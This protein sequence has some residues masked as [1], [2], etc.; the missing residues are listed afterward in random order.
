MIEGANHMN[1]SFSEHRSGVSETKQNFSKLV[2]EVAGGEVR[3][4]VEKN[5]LPVAAI[6]STNDYERFKMMEADRARRIEAIK[7]MSDSL[8][9]IPLETLE[10]EVEKAIAESR[11]KYIVSGAERE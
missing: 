2:N 9:H 11:G 6:I 7:R 3:V 4:V 10:A 5:G 1:I 8:A